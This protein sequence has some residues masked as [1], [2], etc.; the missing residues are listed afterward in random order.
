MRFQT[1][2]LIV[3]SILWQVVTP[4]H[5]AY[6]LLDML[7]EAATGAVAALAKPRPWPPGAAEDEAAAPADAAEKKKTAKDDKKAKDAVTKSARA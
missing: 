5:V 2:G 4:E 1:K 3:G 6:P 7:C